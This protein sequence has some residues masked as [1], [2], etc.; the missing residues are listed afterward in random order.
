MNILA[1][2]SAALTASVAVMKDGVSIYENNVTVA[3]THSETLMPMIDEALK[4][5]N[6]TPNDIDVYAVSQGPGSFTG[7][8]IGVSTIKA[9]AY[10]A[11][12]KAFG[13][14]TLLALAYNVYGV[15][16]YNIAPIMDAR[17]GEVYNAVYSFKNGETQELAAPRALP[18]EELCKEINEKTLF[19]GDGVA[20]YREKIA[21]LCG[22]ENAIFAPPTLQLEKASSVALAA[23]L[24]NEDQ[25]VTAQALEVIYLRKSQAERERENALSAKS[26]V[27]LQNSD[28]QR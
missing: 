15:C 5:T 16:P 11:D 1:V 26:T 22:G 21:S 19:I 24:A 4:S 14:N 10:A 8:R 6:L 25:Y 18:V 23:H 3:L 2:D 20:P 9:L 28:V 12:K 17:R 13:V 27:I 7:V